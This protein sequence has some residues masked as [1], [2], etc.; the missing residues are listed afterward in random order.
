MRLQERVPHAGLRDIMRGAFKEAFKASGLTHREY[1]AKFRGDVAY[2]IRDK[3]S[4]SDKLAAHLQNLG[5]VVEIRVYD[6]EQ[7]P[8]VTTPWRL[9]DTSGWE[10]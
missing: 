10:L 9:V 3:R 8:V 6:P 2:L 5:Y 4:S 7:G 1:R